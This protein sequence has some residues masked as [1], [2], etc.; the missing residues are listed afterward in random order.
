VSGYESRPTGEGYET[1][2]L[3]LRTGTLIGLGDSI[4][5]GVAASGCF[6]EADKLFERSEF[7]SAVGK[8]PDAA[9]K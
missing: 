5:F 6:P 3:R 1:S 4:E 2:S 8:Y 7:L 9:G